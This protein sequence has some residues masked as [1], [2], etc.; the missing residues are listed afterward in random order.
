MKRGSICRPCNCDIS[1]TC[2]HVTGE[3]IDLEPKDTDTDNCDACDSC[4]TTLLSDLSNMENELHNIKIRIQN[5]SASSMSRERMKKIEELTRAT[6]ILV[7]RYRLTINSQKMTINVLETDT[8]GLSRDIDVLES[9]VNMNSRNAQKLLNEID[10]TKEQSDDLFRRLLFVFRNIQV[11]LKRLESLDAAGSVLPSGEYTKKLA[12]AERMMTEMRNRNFD[13]QKTDAEDE[14]TDAKNLLRDVKSELL[15]RQ[16]DNQHLAKRI[17]DSLTNYESKLVDLQEALEDATDLIKQASDMNKDN[18]KS[19]QDIKNR[20][21]DVGKQ[22]NNISYSLTEARTS[23]KQTSDLL[24]MLDA[25]REEYEKLA[26]QLDGARQELGDKVLRLSQA[27]GKEPLVRRA[28]EHALALQNLANQMAEMKKNA[29]DD[30]LVRR[31]NDAAKAYRDII[32]AVKAAEAAANAAKSAASK[33]FETVEKEGL[34]ANARNLKADSSRLLSEANAVQGQLQGQAENLQD[35]K[36]RLVGANQKKDSLEN[37]LKRAQ[38][39]LS[40]IRRDDIADKIASANR[41]IGSANEV[42]DGVVTKLQPI[43]DE[44]D[45]I[46]LRV[47]SGSS[48]DYNKL[49]AEADSSVKKLTS[50]IPDLLRKLNSTHQ[51]LMPLSNISENVNRIRELIQQARDAADKVTVP[52]KFNGKSGVEVRPPSDLDDLKAY[53][54]LSLYVHQ[55]KDRGDGNKASQFI[56]YLGNKDASRDYIG[57]AIRDGSLIC[58]YNLGGTEKEIAVKASVTNSDYK[59]SYLVYVKF[60]RIYQHAVLTYIQKFNSTSD[61]EPEILSEVSNYENTLLNL[62]PNN[63]VFYVGGYPPDF[64]PPPKLKFAFMEGCIELDILNDRV[65]SLYNFKSIM[66]LNTTT[67]PPCKRHRTQVQTFYFE[68]TGYALI[69]PEKSI[70]YD[71][72]IQTTYDKGLLIFLE[73]EGQFFSIEL[74]DGYPVVRYKTETNPVVEQQIDDHMSDGTFYKLQV[75]P[76]TAG[77]F[78][79]ITKS[80]NTKID[81]GLKPF[82]NNLLYLGGLPTE[83]RERYN[84]TAPPFQGFVKDVKIDSNNAHFTDTVGVSRKYLSDL[85]TVRSATIAKG[86]R[87]NLDSNGFTFPGN[88][89]TSFGFKTQQS[90]GILLHHSKQLSELQVVLDKGL[91]K[92]KLDREELASQKPCSDGQMHYV[93]VSKES[94]GVKMFVDDESASSSTASMRSRPAATTDIAFGGENFDGC[95]TNVFIKKANPYA[96]VENLALSKSKNN[97]SLGIC[98][99]EK[100]PQSMMLK[101]TEHPNSYK[102]VKNGKVNGKPDLSGK[103]NSELGLK[104]CALLSP[105]NAVSGAYHFGESPASHLEYAFSPKLLQ[106]RSHF[107]IDVNTTSSDGLIFYAANELQGSFLALYLSNGRFVFSFGAGGKRARIKSKDI[108]TD[109]QWHTVVFSRDGKNGRLVIDGLRVQ[110]GALPTDAA[111]DLKSPF[112]LGAAP[113]V[114]GRYRL[115]DMPRNTFSGCAKNFK[116]NGHLMNAPSEVFG[117][118]PCYVGSTESGVYFSGEGGYVILDNSFVVGNNIEL[119]FEIRPRNHAGVLFHVNSQQGSYLSLYMN[120]GTVVVHVNNGAGDFWTSVS[121]QLSLCDGQWHTVALIKRKNVVQLDVDTE[122]THTIGPSDAYS[123]DTKDP[124]YIGGIPDTIQMPWL[125][126]HSAFTGCLRKVKINEVSVELSKAVE[127]RGAVNLSRCPS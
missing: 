81:T 6:K 67:D 98:A 64:K 100:P 86:G 66:N 4:V 12:E 21:R 74:Q 20:I 101:E 91:V 15:R 55:P 115:K 62:D 3:C 92:V 82:N 78:I 89:Q 124:F 27:A 42:T 106:K 52:M 97:V 25:S 113:T 87:L 108:Y 1:K 38:A 61:R 36:T 24:R 22:Q 103:E 14:N 109:T 49:V 120:K 79:V 2:D 121:P 50:T 85:L 60:E 39:K 31:A 114:S 28:E 46:K 48:G 29:S 94:S 126:A 5:A 116:V 96:A 54:S 71:V 32:D 99:I 117:V 59:E 125:P 40:S 95:I 123:T 13:P 43:K 17:R 73:Y 7:D 44:L 65:I 80:K 84:I 72:M 76:R 110:D 127:I 83:L 111:V 118:V 35:A 51:Q 30:E 90:D 34:P 10:K 70:R 33:A 57:M 122:T 107:S 105:V 19:L 23:L 16:E 41:T 68:G 69:K 45:G 56:M 9:K 18:S 63:V 47:G 93:S 58:V 75:I 77:R 8:L 119:V 26:A 53:T 102:T 88:F 37:D 112:F 104:S 11:L